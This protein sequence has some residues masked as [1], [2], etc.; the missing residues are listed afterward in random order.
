MCSGDEQLWLW[1]GSLEVALVG[2]NAVAKDSREC[3]ATPTDGDN[4]APAINR[5][6]T[7]DCTACPTDTQTD[8]RIA[9]PAS[10]QL[11]KR[12]GERKGGKLR[13]TAMPVLSLRRALKRRSWLS[14]L[15]SC[16]P[17][18]LSSR[19]HGWSKICCVV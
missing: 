6:R 10:T 8:A 18:L 5:M 4:A 2:D 12:V 9:R 15:S 11:L 1:L 17:A 13:L 16:T 3:A 7:M 14:A 19:I